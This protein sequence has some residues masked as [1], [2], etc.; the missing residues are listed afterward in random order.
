MS[1]RKSPQHAKAHYLYMNT[2]LTQEQISKAAAVTRKTVGKWIKKENWAAQKQARYYSPDQEVQQL[3]EQFRKIN[4]RIAKR[5]EEGG[6]ITKE[7]V[8]LKAKP[9]ALIALLEKHAGN[10][11][12]IAP[13]YDAHNPNIINL[14]ALSSLEKKNLEKRQQAAEEDARLGPGKRFS[15]E[16]LNDYYIKIANL[17][18]AADSSASKVGKDGKPLAEDDPQRLKWEERMRQG[19]RPFVDDDEYRKEESGHEDKKNDDFPDCETGM[20][21]PEEEGQE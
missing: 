17:K 1:I 15:E 21:K 11:R 4:E 19:K 18:F 12:N 3:Y 13:E 8:E 16:E 6:I 7:E 14:S 9:G 5:T 20:D 2:S 10:W